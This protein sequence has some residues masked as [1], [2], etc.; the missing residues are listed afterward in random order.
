[1]NRDTQV[2]IADNQRVDRSYL[3]PRNRAILEALQRGHTYQ[4]VAEKF[5]LSRGAVKNIAYDALKQYKNSLRC[6]D[7]MVAR[8]CSK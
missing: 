1:M 6:A 2:N 4:Q 3:E 7:P 5:S 8:G